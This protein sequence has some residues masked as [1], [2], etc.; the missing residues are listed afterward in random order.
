MSDRPYIFGL[1]SNGIEVQLL[2]DFGSTTKNFSHQIPGVVAKHL[3]RLKSGQLIAASDSN[4]YSIVKSVDFT[5]YNCGMLNNHFSRKCPFAQQHT[6][7]PE[8]NNVANSPASHKITCSNFKFV[9]QKIGEYELPLMDV[10]EIRLT[11]KNAQHIY[12]AEKTMDGSRDFLITKFF[13]AD[14][15]VKFRRVFD[16]TENII[17]YIE[18]KPSVSFGL[19]RKNAANMASILFCQ[20]Q[21]RINH[22]YCIESNGIVTFN[23]Q[24]AKQKKDEEHDVE[25]K[26]L[27]SASFIHFILDWNN[28]WAVN[29]S[30]SDTNL[31][32]SPCI[33][34]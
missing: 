32:I 12:C 28:K 30:M 22:F 31:I 25:L 34:L 10:H 20:N 5:C 7:C 21:I 23:I 2:K 4:L 11:F 18:M 14:S 26:I 27:S 19:F 33:E 6:R 24:S 29:I 16:Q 1:S 17:I 8:C 9:S 3:I 13:S 15:N